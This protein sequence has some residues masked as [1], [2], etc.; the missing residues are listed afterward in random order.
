MK[1]SELVHVRFADVPLITWR[2]EVFGQAPLGI[3]RMLGLPARAARVFLVH[4]DEVLL[5][6]RSG[7]VDH[8][9]VQD[10]SAEGWVDMGD[11]SADEDLAPGDYAA[12]GERETA[13]ELGLTVTRYD[14]T[15]IAYYLFRTATT[16]PPEWTKVYVVEHDPEKHGPVAPNEEVASVQW[17]GVRDAREWSQRAPHEFEPGAPLAF[18]HL[19]K[20][21]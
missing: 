6:E 1:M 3:V 21:F 17:V 10:C 12:A 15:E 9:G 13:E 7:T 4:G 18:E 20:S 19:A 14:L 2:D 8:G 5:Q 16:N 11:V